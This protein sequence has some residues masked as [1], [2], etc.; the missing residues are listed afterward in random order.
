VLSRG[1]S[2]TTRSHTRGV[3]AGAGERS[4]CTGRLRPPATAHAHGTR[5]RHTLTAHAHGTRSR[6]T[7]TAH[8]RG[9]GARQARGGQA[10]PRSRSPLPLPASAPCPCSPPPLLRLPTPAPAAAV[11]LTLTH[12]RSRSRSRYGR[13]LRRQRTAEN[14]RE[15]GSILGRHTAR[16]WAWPSC[17]LMPSRHHMPSHAMGSHRRR[18]AS[19]PRAAA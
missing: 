10:E 9:R 1:E 16:P 2:L 5:S 4:S 12:S 11:A 7:L 13:L 14:C 6:H 18:P 15:L 8:A 3:T 17:H 19:V